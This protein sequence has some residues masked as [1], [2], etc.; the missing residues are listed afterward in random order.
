MSFHTGKYSTLSLAPTIVQR[1]PAEW[2]I[3]NHMIDF[4]I[5]NVDIVDYLRRDLA[6]NYDVL[7]K[8]ADFKEWLRDKESEIRK[9]FNFKLNTNDLLTKYD[10]AI[11]QLEISDSHLLANLQKSLK[12]CQDKIER[13]KSDKT[14]AAAE[15]EKRINHAMETIK[16]IQGTISTLIGKGAKVK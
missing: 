14:L 13:D 6:E 1:T 7:Y 10:N 5:D 11:D 9:V 4:Q 2:K 8:R 15:K 3:I 12:E 16:N